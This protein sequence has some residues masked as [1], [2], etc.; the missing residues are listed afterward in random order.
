MRNLLLCVLCV[1]AVLMVAAPTLAQC[2]NG[3]CPNG[4]CDRAPSAIPAPRVN[5][6]VDTAVDAYFL[7]YRN[8]QAAK[9]ADIANALKRL[10]SA[11]QAKQLAPSAPTAPPKAETPQERI[12]EKAEEVKDAVLESPFLRTL[13]VLVVLGLV[14][15]LGHAIYVK[16]HADKAKIDENLKDH[17]MLQSLFDKMDDF[18]TKFENKIHGVT[19]DQ[20]T[21]NSDLVKV[22]LATPAPSQVTV[23]LQSS[24]AV[25]IARFRLPRRPL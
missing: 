14:L 17:P 19:T 9:D 6:Q 21:A 13:A 10:E 1:V 25:S 18:N 23:A 2:Q 7:K 5:V 22:A 3:Q 12:K 20:K 24:Q 16:C 4:Q 8:E 15:A 11:I